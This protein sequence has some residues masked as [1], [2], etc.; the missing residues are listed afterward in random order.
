MDP[1]FQIMRNKFA[2]QVPEVPLIKDDEL[3]Q[4]LGPD[5]LHE[6]FSMRVAVWSA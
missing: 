2:K 1:L 3:I 4:A 6:A 5:S